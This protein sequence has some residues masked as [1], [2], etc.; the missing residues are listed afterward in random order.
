MSIVIEEDDYILG[1]WVADGPEGNALTL[2]K[3]KLGERWHI[4]TR[5]RNYI[6]DKVWDSKD[7]K[8]FYEWT[9]D[10]DYT[11]DQLIDIGREVSRLAV[12]LGIAVD[13]HESIVKGLGLP[14]FERGI[15][16]LPGMHTKSEI[17]H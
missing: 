10:I 11:E 8:Q 6:D 7:T 13:I 17:I 12:E 14:A 1:I 5:I 2:I 16:I 3:R 4:H 15:S 9:T